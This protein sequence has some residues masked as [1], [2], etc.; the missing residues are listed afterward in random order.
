MREIIRKQVEMSVM[1][2]L[3]GKKDETRISNV[4]LFWHGEFGPV[5]EAFVNICRIKE[6]GKVYEG[7]FDS[8]TVN[9]DDYL[10]HDH[11]KKWFKNLVDDITTLVMDMVD[12]YGDMKLDMDN[13]L[14]DMSKQVFNM[15]KIK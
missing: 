7:A 3:M 12:P 8:M 11:Y 15:T 2:F 4:L 14:K 13:L 5:T 10:L 9:L 6:D 1:N